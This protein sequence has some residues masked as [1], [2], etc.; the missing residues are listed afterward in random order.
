MCTIAADVVNIYMKCIGV[1]IKTKQKKI[2]N[3]INK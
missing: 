2:F 3:F 1:L